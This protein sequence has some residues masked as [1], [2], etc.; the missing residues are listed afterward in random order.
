MNVNFEITDIFTQNRS[1]K[2]Q[3]STFNF[4]FN[5]KFQVIDSNS[6]NGFLINSIIEK[7]AEE[8]LIFVDREGNNSYNYFYWING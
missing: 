2:A 1:K 6:E 3:Y 5:F 7:L 8:C 4:N